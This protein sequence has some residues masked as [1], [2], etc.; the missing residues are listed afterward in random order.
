MLPI[1]LEIRNFL[2]YRSPD[3]IRFDGI[4][5]ACLTG[6]NGAG[7]SSLLDAITWALWG[8]ARAKR[9]DDL[10]HQGQQDML[11][12]LDFEQEGTLYR[13]VRKRARA[14]RAASSLD[15][16]VFQENGTPTLINEPSLR[17]TQAKIN[18]LL[19]LD[20]ET[21]VHS[22]FLQQGK[23][24]AFTVINP[25]ERKRILSDILGLESWARYEERAKQIIKATENEIYSRE[26]SIR[27]INEN[28]AREPHY[29]QAIA[30]AQ[31][32]YEDAQQALDRAQARL[33][34]VAHAPKEYHRVEQ[35][36]ADLERAIRERERD[37]AY[38]E[39]EITRQQ[40]KVQTY[41]DLLA[42]RE[43]IESGYSILQQAREADSELGDKLAQ[44]R[45]LDKD[46]HDL[47]RQLDAARADQES[48]RNAIL[49][50]IE[51]L[52]R[53]LHPEGL[54]EAEALLKDINELE[55]L[56]LH[57]DTLRERIAQLEADKAALQAS[58][59]ALTPEGKVLKERL[60]QLKSADSAVCPLCGQ[61]LTP[62][63]LAQVIQD[64]EAE[65]DQKRKQ[66]A[67]NQNKMKAIDGELRQSRAQLEQMTRDLRPLPALREKAGGI[68]KLREKA[69]EA[70][71]RLIIERANLEAVEA[72]I[73]N[74]QYAMETRN[75]LAQ[76][77]AEREG[78]AYDEAVHH[79][80]RASLE[81]H[82]EYESQHTRLQLAI[83]A[84]PEAQ[85]ELE[86]ARA[87]LER[88]TKTLQED[89]DKLEQLHAESASLEV[90]AKEEQARREEV[91][92]QRTI[93]NSA[94]ERL[95]TA[96]QELLSLEQ[97]RRRKEELIG[98][99]EGLRHKEA[100]YSELSKAFGKNGVPVM[101]IE[102]VIPELEAEANYLLGRM[103]DGRMSLRLNTQR[104]K[105]TGG[106]TETLD[107][108]IADELG[109]RPYELYSGGEAFR[110]NFAIRIA[111]SKL[112]ARRA[113]AHLRTL[114]IDE[115]FGSQDDDGRSKLVE[116]ITAIQDEFDLL[117]VITHI[118]D[119]RDS[120]PVHLLIEKTDN[121][122]RVSMR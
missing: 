70:E 85:A 37:I 26:L 22:A 94:H 110:I 95:I 69:H 34:E 107:I 43:A 19:R 15:L 3:A 35:Q 13:V 60:E 16:F 120:F 17:D 7:K 6:A 56:E 91:N 86:G 122:S 121:G 33:E 112:L 44:I 72:L 99:L 98:L 106:M 102:T 116:A 32:A 64:L 54:D 68:L 8:Q 93:A 48:D 4:H 27:E 76:L 5:L 101:I 23:A 97:Q 36:I 51:E 10:I 57:R 52:E 88:H 18:R 28:L 55:Q 96:R 105:V 89:K 1:R 65:V 12:Q 92:L 39:Q 83:E 115:G 41:L 53:S 38:I 62:E 82:R 46:I 111:L 30:S 117:L 81:Q 78:L 61:P 75:A 77:L 31:S 118:D 79:A 49:A 100:L 108:E 103:T 11:V 14:R 109:T 84:L 104:E 74:E 73:A 40:A 2:P 87:K 119:L 90:L 9:D 25:A 67:S 71:R 45:R 29:R 20:Y 58:Q 47:Q 80:T 50:R 63:H 66:Y 42:Q 59:E 21:F 113:G 24:D 114:F